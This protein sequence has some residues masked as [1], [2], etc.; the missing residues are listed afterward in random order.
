MLTRRYDDTQQTWVEADSLPQGHTDWVRDVAWAP[1]IGN[2]I[3]VIAS[4]SQDKR[5]IIWKHEG[6]EWKKQVLEMPY[7]VWS[8]S[9]SA[10]GA[11]SCLGH[12]PPDAGRSPAHAPT[13]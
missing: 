12:T 9:W 8:V 2:G 10:T 5:V 13:S 6:S 4:C 3:D 1:S 7:L 11:H